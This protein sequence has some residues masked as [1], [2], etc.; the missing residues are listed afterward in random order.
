MQELENEDA[1]QHLP[2]VVA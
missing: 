1:E 2:H